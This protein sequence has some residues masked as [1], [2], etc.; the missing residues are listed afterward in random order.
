MG[1]AH[2]EFDL[3]DPE[4]V[5]GHDAQHPRIVDDSVADH[6]DPAQP[7]HHQT[8]DGV[9]LAL[10]ELHTTRSLELGSPP[11]IEPFSAGRIFSTIDST[12][13]NRHGLLVQTESRVGHLAQVEPGLT[14]VDGFVSIRAGEDQEGIELSDSSSASRRCTAGHRASRRQETSS[15][16]SRL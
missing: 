5:H 12:N 15:A 3:V 6:G 4:A 10:W 2:G 16:S 8:A 13:G 7:I 14:R 9:V 1:F 11:A